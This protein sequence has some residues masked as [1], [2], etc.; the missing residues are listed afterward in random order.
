MRFG[1]D[2]LLELKEEGVRNYLHYAALVSTLLTIYAM[3]FLASGSSL[4]V[5]I[6]LIAY[7]LF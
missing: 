7:Y 3:R 5:A 6:Y 4:K 1:L 2:A